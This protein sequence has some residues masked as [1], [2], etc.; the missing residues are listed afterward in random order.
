[1]RVATF[2]ASSWMASKVKEVGSMWLDRKRQPTADVL[3]PRDKMHSA[4][5][6]RMRHSSQMLLMAL[7]MNS[8][9]LLNCPPLRKGQRQG[10]RIRPP[11]PLR[12]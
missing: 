1:M 9:R 12:L 3:S 6:L 5:S 8:N 2:Q 11:R 10:M 7:P 4:S